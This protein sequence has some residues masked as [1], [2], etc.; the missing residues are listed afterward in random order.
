MGSILEQVDGKGAEV[1]AR[2]PLCGH[3][4]R[5][6]NYCRHVRW[7]FDQGGPIDFARYALE[8]SPYVYGR[9]ANPRD[10]PH[11]WWEQNGEWLLES[12]ELRFHV[13]EGYVF[14]ELAALDLIARDIWK[15]FRPDV[16][17]PAIAIAE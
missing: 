3:E 5:Y 16:E 6:L 12:L 4:N 15:R 1:A 9:Y 7:T 13:G 10:I 14:G 17:R 2:C 8:T 11:G